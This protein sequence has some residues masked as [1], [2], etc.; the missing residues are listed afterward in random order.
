MAIKVGGD[1]QESDKDSS[2]IN[3]KIDGNLK[4]DVNSVEDN[5]KKGVTS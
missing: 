2:F 4:D 5:L 3:I 1:I